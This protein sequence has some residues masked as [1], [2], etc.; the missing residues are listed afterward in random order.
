MW[1]K[2]NEKLILELNRL[3]RRHFPLL[4]T[5]YK[6]ITDSLETTTFGAW[7]TLSLN[8]DI[9]VHPHYD[10]KD[11]KNGFCWIVPFGSY[12]GGNLCFQELDVEVE[13]AAGDV[14][15]FQSSCLYHWVK[16]YSGH[17]YS[18]VLF[19]HQTMFIPTK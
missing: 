6:S 7:C 1:I 9:A 8:I 11:Y 4:F 14:C 5:E 12:Q 15:C 10:K 3:F 2:K 13:L 16:P 19:T 17:R 18:L